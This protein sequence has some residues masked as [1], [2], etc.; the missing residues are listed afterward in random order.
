MSGRGKGVSPKEKKLTKGLGRGILSKRER[1]EEYSQ[2]TEE[3]GQLKEMGYTEELSIHSLSTTKERGEISVDRAVEWLLLENNIENFTKNKKRKL[4]SILFEC[5]FGDIGNIGYRDKP[6]LYYLDKFRQAMDEKFR[7]KEMND[8]LPKELWVDDYSPAELMIIDII[9]RRGKISNYHFRKFIS[10]CTFDNFDIC[11]YEGDEEDEDDED[12]E[13]RM[14]HESDGEEKE[15]EDEGV[16]GKEEFFYN[17]NN[18]NNND[19]K[20]STKVNIL[21][22]DNLTYKTR[23]NVEE[24]EENRKQKQN[25]DLGAIRYEDFIGYLYRLGRGKLYCSRC[26]TAWNGR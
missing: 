20:G 4:G 23:A 5:K 24:I 13:I 2:W 11:D 7:A 21:D 8:A 18:N 15:E 10:E 9:K 6:E 25:L 17:N 26:Q 22:I 1:E 14:N 12:S 16:E 3:I 19:T